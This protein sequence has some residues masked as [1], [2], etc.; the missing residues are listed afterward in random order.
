MISL[1]SLQQA[2]ASP[3]CVALAADTTLALATMQDVRDAVSPVFSPFLLVASFVATPAFAVSLIPVVLVTAAAN[4]KVPTPLASVTQDQWVKLLICVAIDVLGDAGDV[5][6]FK[7]LS[8]RDGLLTTFRRS[9]NRTFDWSLRFFC[10]EKRLCEFSHHTGA[11]TPRGMAAFFRR[12]PPRLHRESAVCSQSH[13]VVSYLS[14][15]CAIATAGLERRNFRPKFCSGRS[16]SSPP[17]LIANNAQ[18]RLL[19]LDIERKKK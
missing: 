6:P 2:A 4:H 14:R 11:W 18:A 10:A 3:R 9:R 12:S 13:L 5:A 15:S 7:G 1:P 17:A 19:G 8:C 16:R